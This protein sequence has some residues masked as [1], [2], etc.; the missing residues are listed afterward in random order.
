M[1]QLLSSLFVPRKDVNPSRNDATAINNTR[2]NGDAHPIYQFKLVVL[3]DTSVGKS[4]IVGR[5]V[6]NTF[7]EYQE[8]TIGGVF[9]EQCAFVAA[10]MTQ[11]LKL[12]NYAVKFEI[13]DTAGCV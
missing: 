2:T 5:F 7:G 1:K 12:D 8:S 10:F 13:W 3:G 9:N 11:T 4:C 6:K